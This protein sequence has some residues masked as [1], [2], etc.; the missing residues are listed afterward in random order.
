MIWNTCYLPPDPNQ[1]QGRSD[2]PPQAAFFQIVQMLN[3]L[4]MPS[5]QFSKPAFALI[6]F[7]CDEGI[8]RNQGRVGAVEGPTAIRQ[9]LAKL[10]IHKPHL[11]CLDAGNIFC[12][13]GN[14]EAA[15]E[16]LAEVIE[17][18]HNH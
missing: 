5:L 17:I 4:E 14:L 2:T 18:L 16:S 7:R 1:W 6:G 15:Q 12:L 8:R 9:T 10:P 3:L 13:D 11:I